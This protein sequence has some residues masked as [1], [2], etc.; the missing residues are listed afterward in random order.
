[1]RSIVR[2]GLDTVFTGLRYLAN[3][4]Q[5]LTAS[6]VDYEHPMLQAPADLVLSPLGATQAAPTSNTS[7]EMGVG[8]RWHRMTAQLV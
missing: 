8:G 4:N 1:M 3:C 2:L 6:L 5:L 7:N